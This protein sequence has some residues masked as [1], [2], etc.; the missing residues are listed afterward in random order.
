MSNIIYPKL[1]LPRLASR[2]FDPLYNLILPPRDSKDSGNT[3]RFIDRHTKTLVAAI[4][5]S[6]G[7]D[8]SQFGVEIKSKYNDTN[9][10]WTIGTMTLLDIIN[11]PMYKDTEI[12][13]KMQAL[14]LCTCDDNLRK[15]IDIGLYYMDMDEIQ[16][17]LENS[18]LGA[19]T[20]ILKFVLPFWGKNQPIDWK[21]NFQNFKGP[22]AK[23][24]RTA[25]VNSL[26]FRITSSDM[27][28]LKNIAST[29]YSFNLNFAESY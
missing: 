11:T 7:P 25:S 17:L 1:N 14:L 26:A 2:T 19:R 5:S 9:T 15:I 12:Y 4:L 29:A 28:H 20:Q 3:G 16:I 21:S 10:D 23:F 22:Y 8:L 27:E 24:E 18:Y 13:Q 6:K